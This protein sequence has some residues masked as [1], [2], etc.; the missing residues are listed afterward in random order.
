MLSGNGAHLLA[1]VFRAEACI[2]CVRRVHVALA[3][4]AESEN[5]HKLVLRLG[6]CI[7]PLQLLVQKAPYASAWIA[8]KC[9]INDPSAVKVFATTSG[10]TFR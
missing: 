5:R 2:A 1:N 8:K 4:F 10:G 7:P 6:H 9:R 3:E